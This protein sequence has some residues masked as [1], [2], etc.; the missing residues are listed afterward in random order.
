MVH[1]LMPKTSDC[2]QAGRS[3]RAL[4]SHANERF[5]TLETAGASTSIKIN[6]VC[7]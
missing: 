2:N 3:A 5:V 6:G 7:K 4:P 1:E